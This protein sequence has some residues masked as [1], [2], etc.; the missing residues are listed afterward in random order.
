MPAMRSLLAEGFTAAARVDVAYVDQGRV[1]QSHR[2]VQGARHVGCRFHGSG[3][4]RE[5]S[6][7]AVCRQR[8]RRARS[9]RGAR[10]PPVT[11]AMPADTPA[12]FFAECEL[13][14]ATV[15]RVSGTIADAGRY[16][17]ELGLRDTFDVST[18]REPFR[19]EGKKTMA[20]ELVEQLGGEVPD[21]IVLSDRGRHGDSS[22]CGRPSTRWKRWVG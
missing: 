9:L 10:R 4:G 16:L 14:G 1:A 2:V 22:A 12:A 3:A 8:R 11:V 19:I 15:H 17:R 6:V 7:G 20:Y 5:G 18:L 13:Y 21:V